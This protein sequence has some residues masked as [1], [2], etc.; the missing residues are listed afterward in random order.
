MDVSESKEDEEFLYKEVLRSSVIEKIMSSDKTIF[1]GLLV[2]RLVNA[3]LIQTSFVPDEF[4]QSVEVA[5]KMIFE[6]PLQV[7]YFNIYYI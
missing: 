2:I 7:Y 6:Y 3:M 5:H 1:L 4:W